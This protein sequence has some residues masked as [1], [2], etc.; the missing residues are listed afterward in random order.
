MKP[1]VYLT[2]TI[3]AAA[4]GDNDKPATWRDG[5][6]QISEAFC[7]ARIDC[8]LDPEEERSACEQYNIDGLCEQWDCDLPLSDEHAQL[9]D[10]CAEDLDLWTCSPW[11]PDS[12]Y[13]ILRTEQQ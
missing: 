11:L 6:V 12:C 2:I 9:F 7:N 4:C 3:L 1:T 5:V 8:R 13:V 10:Y